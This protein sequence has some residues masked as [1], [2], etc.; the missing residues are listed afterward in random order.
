MRH[1]PLVPAG[2][3]AG[4]NVPGAGGV[5]GGR[6]E[7]PRLPG[8]RWLQV[9]LRVCGRRGGGPPPSVGRRFTTADGGAL[10]RALGGLSLSPL[11]DVPVA[12]VQRRLLSSLGFPLVAVP[13]AT[14]GMGS[15]LTA[16]AAAVAR[17]LCAHQGGELAGGGGAARLRRMG[18]GALAR[19]GA[20]ILPA[21]A[22][23]VATA[24]VK[25]TPA[26]VSA[27]AT[28]TTLA[29]SMSRRWTTRATPRTPPS[30]CTPWSAS[31][32]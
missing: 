28:P 29:S 1:C 11:P 15:N 2:R 14:G 32:P 4:G 21:V 24:E 26:T 31:T 10:T 25:T 18:S 12:V 5:W 22:S 13:E 7:P 9:C 6:R 20:T 17:L 3:A 30:R 8:G 16:K 19:V 27:V 23:V